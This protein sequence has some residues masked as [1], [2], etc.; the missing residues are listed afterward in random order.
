MP[1]KNLS[2]LCN[3]PRFDV[4]TKADL[5]SRS[6]LKLRSVSTP[7]WGSAARPWRHHS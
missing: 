5:G 4:N 7:T 6:R 1:G 2:M 3:E